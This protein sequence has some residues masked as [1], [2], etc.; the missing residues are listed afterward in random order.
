MLSFARRQQCSGLAD[1][2]WNA[3]MQC[4][5]EALDYRVILTAAATAAGC[6]M[7]V[8]YTCRSFAFDKF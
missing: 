1:W 2:Q 8:H 5:G 7:R 6:A 4:R 3:C